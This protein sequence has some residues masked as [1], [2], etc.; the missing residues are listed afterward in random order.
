MK[1]YPQVIREAHYFVGIDAPHE[2]YMAQIEQES[3]CDEGVTAFDSG[4][5]LGQFMD[6]TA[7][8][9]QEREAAL[10]EISVEPHPYDPRWSIRA[11][12]LYDNYLYQRT[13]CQEWYF[14]ERAYNGGLGL[15]NREIKRAGTCDRKAVE[16]QCR[17]KVLM[18]K[19]GKLD[20]CRDVNIPYFYL[21]EKKAQ[22]YKR[23]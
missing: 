18:L 22:K 1:Y 16:A 8:W 6:D 3:R 13:L 12:I 15:I 4:R 7:E 23:D 10:R 5:G 2:I 11:L 20:L 19:T 17:R 14:A 21:I 9:L